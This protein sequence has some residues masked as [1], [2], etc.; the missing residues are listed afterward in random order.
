MS[1]FT[2]SFDEASRDRREPTDRSG[3]LRI[4]TVCTGNIARSAFAA[5]LIHDRAERLPASILVSSAGTNAMVD[6]SATAEMHELGR[7]I[8]L[9]LTGH[10]GRQL[11][12]E[13][14]LESDLV[15]T[16][17]REHR[18]AAVRLVPSARPRAFTLIEFA[19]AST[20]A[21]ASGTTGS[22]DRAF[23]DD[24]VGVRPTLLP[25]I[26]PDDDDI[27]DPYRQP[28]SVN[29]EVAVQIASAVA[30]IFD[31]GASSAEFE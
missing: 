24:V 21:R 26:A 27:V 2:F 3:A 18:A 22:F 4:L 13:L 19:R 12:E 29:R 6:F 15:L 17:T 20:A 31:E 16:A 30:E 25:L 5:A 14:I 7:A 1:R 10:R 28:M 11:T 8:G 23:V 9:D